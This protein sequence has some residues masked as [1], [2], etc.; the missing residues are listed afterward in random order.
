[1]ATTASTICSIGIYG[2]FGLNVDGIVGLIVSVVVMVAGVNIAKD[3]LAPLIGEESTLRST[4]RSAILWRALTVLW[5][6]MI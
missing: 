3:T 5:E 4:R 1:M 6:P 2:A